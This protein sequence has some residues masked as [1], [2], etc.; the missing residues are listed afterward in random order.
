MKF[1]IDR[2]QLLEKLNQVSRAISSNSPYPALS[3]IL[4]NVKNDKIVLTGNDNDITI[5]TEIHPGELTSLSVFE[6]GNVLLESRYFLEIV[7]KMDSVI[8]EI[9]DDLTN[10]VTIRD[11]NASFRLND[12]KA[13]TYPTISLERPE[14]QILINSEGLRS[15]INQTVFATSEKNA[16][17][18]LAGVNF[19]CENGILN[20]AA[21]DAYRLARKTIELPEQGEFNITIPSKALQEIIKF[22]TPGE[23]RPIQIFADKKKAQFIL[24]G[25]IFQT[26]LIE[27][28]FPE[29]S[30]IIPTHNIST[31]LQLDG[32][33]IL[34]VIDRTNFLTSEKQHLVK[35]ECSSEQIRVKSQSDEIGA[36]D[37]VLNSFTFEGNNL[38][39]TLN[40]KYLLDAIKVLNAETVLIEFTGTQS[41]LKITNPADDTTV[42]VIVPVRS[43]D[44]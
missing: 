44:D 27:G 5:R 40:G 15:I 22:I 7:K 39:V 1:S 3:G 13:E 38:R 26:R 8:V 35:M 18:V 12:L 31:T 33:E 4:M 14:N 6:P 16:R 42:M 17:P 29:V 34:R 43:Y 10:S 9:A 11:D 37:E 24:D 25:T 28:R 32:P 20:C 21:T 19:C 36:S 23:N 30:K 41:P 2:K